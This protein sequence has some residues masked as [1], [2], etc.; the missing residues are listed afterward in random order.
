MLINRTTLNQAVNDFWGFFLGTEKSWVNKLYR[1]LVS[2]S[3]FIFDDYVKFLVSLEQQTFVQEINFWV[4]LFRNM[5]LFVSDFES[6]YWKKTGAEIQPCK[7]SA[8]IPT[9]SQIKSL[10]NSLPTREQIFMLILE[11]SG[12]RSVDI[13]R[14]KSNQIKT[15]DSKFYATI[16]KDKTHQNQVTFSWEWDLSYLEPSQSIESVKNNFRLLLA[17]S[18]APFANVKVNSIRKSITWRLHGLRHRRAIVLLRAGF[19]TK[20]TM[21]SIGWACE[22]SLFRYTK[23]PLSDLKKFENTEV[24]INFINS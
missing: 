9:E 12:R 22:S 20:D 3:D 4:R 21:S 18:P 1:W 23:L 8:R 24:C 15:I 14:I 2:D 10:I 7:K 19:S 17:E 11:N 13:T 5:G 6:R 16:P